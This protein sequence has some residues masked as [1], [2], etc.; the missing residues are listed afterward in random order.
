MSE[1]QIEADI[2]LGKLR[3]HKLVIKDIPSDG[4]C[5]YHAVADQM[6][7]HNMPIIADVRC[8]S[9]SGNDF[10]VLTL[11]VLLGLAG[12]SVPVPAPHY[13]RVHACSTG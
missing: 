4:H 2:I 9:P 1:R 11:S 10:V 3:Q 12:A 5:M 6:K 8:S 13:G 7:Q